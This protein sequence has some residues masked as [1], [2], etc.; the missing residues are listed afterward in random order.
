MASPPPFPQD[1][2]QA[3]LEWTR[4]YEELAE[5]RSGN[6]TALRRRLLRLSRT[7]AGHPHVQ[8]RG[9]RAPV[10]W[11]ELRRAAR[12]HAQRGEAGMS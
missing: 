6:L 9:G 3:Q 10:A 8:A 7:I 11:G 12:A 1:L 2:L 4:T 5:P